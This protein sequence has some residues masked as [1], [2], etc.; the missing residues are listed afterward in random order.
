MRHVRAE[1][2]DPGRLNG[3]DGD[4]GDEVSYGL[5]DFGGPLRI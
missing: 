1:A 3:W 4:L 2:P 5:D